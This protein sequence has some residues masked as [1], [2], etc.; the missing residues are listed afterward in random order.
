MGF[1]CINTGCKKYSSRNLQR[2]CIVFFIK[3]TKIDH[4]SS[5]QASSTR[6]FQILAKIFKD[7]LRI[8]FF[9]GI[10]MWQTDSDKNRK[11]QARKRK[12]GNRLGVIQGTEADGGEAANRI[13]YGQKTG[14]LKE[15]KGRTENRR[16]GSLLVNSRGSRNVTVCSPVQRKARCCMTVDVP[17][18]DIIKA[19]LRRPL[20]TSLTASLFLSTYWMERWMETEKWKKTT[21]DGNKCSHGKWCIQCT[22]T[23]LH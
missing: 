2:Y 17:C 18:L 21:K 20:L 11:T 7:G 10:E 12:A 1:H 5:T 3:L 16:F 23:V 14:W 6:F 8:F 13:V 19:K 15:M 4:F 9:G 22:Y